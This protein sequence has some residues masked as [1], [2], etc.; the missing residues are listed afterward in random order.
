MVEEIKVN[1]SVLAIIISSSYRGEGIEFFT[2]DDYSQQI[3]Y[4]NRPE[5]YRIQPH[6][7]NK[8]VREISTT[9][10]VLYIKSGRLR[11]DFFDEDK[12][13]IKS[14]ELASG[15]VIFLAS[16]GHGFEMLEDTEIIEVKQGPYCGEEEKTRFDYKGEGTD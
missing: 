11:V 14:R 5:G 13:F 16:G 3:A 6:L 1:G 10:E 2:P 12:R 4:M 8:I 9:Q 7:H 15:D